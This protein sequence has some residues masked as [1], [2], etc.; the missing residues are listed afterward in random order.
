MLG[1]VNDYTQAV[2]AAV[3]GSPFGNVALQKRA[4][5]GVV[6]ALVRESCPIMGAVRP[7]QPDHG[8]RAG[9]G[10]L[11]LEFQGNI[12]RAGKH[13]AHPG[14]RHVPDG[15]PDRRRALGTGDPTL[16]DGGEALVR[17]TLRHSR[18]HARGP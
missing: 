16:Q 2:F 10:N 7:N 1:R 5:T 8:C 4:G 15:T 14:F 18:G 11:E 12:R 17:S 6:S 13:E 3:Q 9:I